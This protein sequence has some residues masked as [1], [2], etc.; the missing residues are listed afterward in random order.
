M[1]NDLL[2][3][4][5]WKF[6][7]GQIQL[8]AFEANVTAWRASGGYGV[9]FEPQPDS[10]EHIIR[11]KAGEPPPELSLIIGD[12]LQN[13]R[14]GL[15]H[16]AH[17]LAAQH[18]DPLPP[19]V[20]ARSEFPIFGDRAMTANERERKIG[21][22]HPDAAAIIDGLQPH[23]RGD[24]YEDDPLWQLHELARIDRHRLSHLTFAQYGGV[25]VGGD[26]LYIEHMTITG[27]GPDLEDGAE[28]GRCSVR[29][30]NPGKP[31]HMNLQSI[32]EIAFKDGPLAGATVSAAFMG[33]L[34]HINDRVVPPLVPFLG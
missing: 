21:A 20:G 5:Q 31:M 23:A 3:S 22:M 24:R 15:D 32:P 16:L 27:G 34:R 13:L 18:T 17:A 28:L 11:L 25:G 9:V 8:Q 6:R 33:V 1:P 30:I 10:P 12:A 19:D 4:F 26:N 2:H 7:W 14:S 29:P